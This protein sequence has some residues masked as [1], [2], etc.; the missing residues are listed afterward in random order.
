MEYGD[1]DGPLRML[2]PGAWAAGLDSQDCFL[3]WLLS[4][5]SRRFLGVRRH[6]SDRLGVYVFFP[7][8]LGPSP[9]WNYR[10]VEETPLFARGVSPS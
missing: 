10:C 5:A 4:P 6:N 1:S 7:L 3:L 9:G 2:R 8:G